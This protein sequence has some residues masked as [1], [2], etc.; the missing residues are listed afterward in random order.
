MIKDNFLQMYIF[1]LHTVPNPA[2]DKHLLFE[3]VSS[4]PIVHLCYN[5]GDLHITPLF[6]PYP[7]CPQPPCCSLRR[8]P[9]T[10]PHPYLPLVFN[11]FLNNTALQPTYSQH[12]AIHIHTQSVIFYSNSI[13]T[14]CSWFRSHP[15]CCRSGKCCFCWFRS[16]W[17]GAWS[18]RCY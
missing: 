7:S 4:H 15:A 1:F 6:P 14:H 16:F 12:S 5:L 9:A 13:R 3:I 17:D 2:S 11:S 10:D 18:N 8:T